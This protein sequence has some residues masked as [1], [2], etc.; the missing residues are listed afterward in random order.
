MGD[1][2]LY[3]DNAEKIS[4]FFDM[5]ISMNGPSTTL[6][7]LMGGK[8]F[9]WADGEYYFMIENDAVTLKGG[10]ITYDGTK[11]QSDK[12]YAKVTISG[13][14]IT[15]SGETSATINIEPPATSASEY[16]LTVG[17]NSYVFS[18]NA[19]IKNSLAY[20]GIFFVEDS[21]NL[22]D[23]KIIQYDGTGNITVSLEGSLAVYN[24][25]SG[26]VS[27]IEG[28]TT[29]AYTFENSELLKE[30]IVSTYDESGEKVSDTITT[31]RAVDIYPNVLE[32]DF[33]ETVNEY[34]K[35]YE[36]NTVNLLSGTLSLEGYTFE[37]VSAENG[38]TLEYD[39]SGFIA[40][41]SNFDEGESILIDNETYTVTNGKI[42][43]A[44]DGEYY[45][46]DTDNFIS[47]MTKDYYWGD[48]TGWQIDGNNA[49]YLLKGATVATVGG[50]N[51][52]GAEAVDGEI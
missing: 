49:V 17:D 21:I 31:A 50:L 16:S 11:L 35:D 22:Y 26:T 6:Q 27:I 5:E 30:I 9:R 15:I 1:L 3:L 32:S 20:S 24:F 7:G 13:T 42:I 45:N 36:N 2:N 23:G 19:S 39:S 8:V 28:D 44:S 37:I 38:I 41:I 34:V 43:R 51:L 12:S 10:A 47:K 29:T 33:S 46:G 48:V 25:S 18:G 14:N 40:G 4:D 52:D